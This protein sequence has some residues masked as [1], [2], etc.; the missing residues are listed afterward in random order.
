MDQ[1]ERELYKQLKKEGYAFE[2]AYD[3]SYVIKKVRAKGPT[4]G[5]H[6]LKC[7]VYS[8]DEQNVNHWIEEIAWELDILDDYDLKPKGKKLK[9]ETYEELL[10]LDFGESPKDMRT[11]LKE[12]SFTYT[13]DSSKKKYPKF[14]ITQEL[15][16]K[17]F[18]VYIA[19]I[20]RVSELLSETTETGG[21]RFK[22]EIA[23]ILRGN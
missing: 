10:K 14:E 18:R 2:M 23:F 5:E 16:E 1:I 6:I 3:R 9:P 12:F 20:K 22:Q 15:I 4:I 11:Q 19:I 21:E 17:L 13:R 7:V 8:N